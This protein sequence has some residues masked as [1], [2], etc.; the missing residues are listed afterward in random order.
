[1]NIYTFVSP[2]VIVVGA[3]L[4][5][6]SHPLI[7]AL[8]KQP[9]GSVKLENITVCFFSGA[10]LFISLRMAIK[11]FEKIYVS[12]ELDT[13]HLYTICASLIVIWNAI[14]GYYKRTW[15]AQLR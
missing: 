3:L 13:E 5:G 14:Q 1:M 9:P 4:T 12:V 10:S 6:L 7:L 15:P 8:N 2:F 11:T